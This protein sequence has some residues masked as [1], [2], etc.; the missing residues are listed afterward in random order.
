ML[1]VTTMSVRP[2]ETRIF[3]GQIYYIK[4]EK[5][6]FLNIF[7]HKYFVLP[8]IIE[9]SSNWEVRS[10]S[11]HRLVLKHN[12]STFPF[13]NVS[14]YATF[15]VCTVLFSQCKH[16]LIAVR[17]HC[18]QIFFDGGMC[19]WNECMCIIALY[20]CHHLTFDPLSRAARAT[21]ICISPK[22]IFQWYWL[23]LLF[24][25][26]LL[27]FCW[28]DTFPAIPSTS[29]Q[30]YIIARL[31][32]PCRWMSR[33]NWRKMSGFYFDVHSMKHIHSIHIQSHT[34]LFDYHT[35]ST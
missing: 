19:T 35:H 12:T 5:F 23:L 33:T 22:C 17:M 2:F 27:G 25:L 20:L 18:V 8:S 28:G 26:L 15:F 14:R 7:W 16:P 31:S 32:V 10:D 29:G 6:N 9:S 24:S 21:A 4:M 11:T 13:C 34:V 1:V 30:C 3:S